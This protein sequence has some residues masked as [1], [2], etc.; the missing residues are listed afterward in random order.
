MKELHYWGIEND[1]NEKKDWLEDYL[2]K[3]NKSLKRSSVILKEEPQ[4]NI[5][6]PPANQDI[7]NGV[8]NLD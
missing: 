5:D 7:S 8:P 4:V 2:E 6:L 3:C 1:T